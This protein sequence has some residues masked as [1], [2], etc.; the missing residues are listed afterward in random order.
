[1][2]KPEIG[3]LVVPNDLFKKKFKHLIFEQSTII[4]VS[5]L[6]IT[7]DPPISNG[8][9]D[10]ELFSSIHSDYLI[11]LDPNSKLVKLLFMK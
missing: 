7:I 2:K 4:Q 5:S 11:V 10:P 1:M 3:D 6:I 8:A 9:T